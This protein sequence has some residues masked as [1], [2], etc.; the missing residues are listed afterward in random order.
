MLSN[1]F[2]NAP[3]TGHVPKLAATFSLWYCFR[4]ENWPRESVMVQI[5]VNHG[6]LAVLF[7]RHTVIVLSSYSHKSMIGEEYD[8]G[9]P[10]HQNVDKLTSDIFKTSQSAQVQVNLASSKVNPRVAAGW[11]N[12]SSASPSVTLVSWSPPYTITDR[13]Q[14]EVAFIAFRLEREFYAQQVPESLSTLPYRRGTK[15]IDATYDGHGLDQAAIICISGTHQDSGDAEPVANLQR[16]GEL[17]SNWTAAIAT[18]YWDNAETCSITAHSVL[19]RK[20]CS[21]SVHDVA[22]EGAPR[23]P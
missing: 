11:R 17:T 2:R 16:R 14:Y 19:Y 10:Q 15:D 3:E 23:S 22:S 13:R 21:P 6:S 1:A 9:Q 8:G 7:T 12:A 20:L 4:E 5:F 18:L